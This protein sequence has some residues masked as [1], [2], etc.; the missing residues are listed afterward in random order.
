MRIAIQRGFLMR[1]IKLDRVAKTGYIVIAAAL[2]ALGVLLL[3][4]P[5]FSLLLFN[6]ILGVLVVVFGIVKLVGFFSED[7]YR[8]AFQYDLAGG[9]LLCTLGIVMLLHP[10]ASITFLCIA[11]GV[12]VMGDGLLRLQVAIDAKRFGLETWWLILTLAILTA[13]GG[14]I[15]IIRPVDAL[16]VIMTLS[17]LT[18][19]AEGGLTLGVA[20]CTIKIS[21]RQLGNE[22]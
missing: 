9:I 18:F 22:T 1:S 14:C 17:G 13:A 6:Y 3:L 21:W 4:K 16:R 11:F 15:L 5:D 10:D 19:L 8:L 7:L 12:L 20:L 2:F